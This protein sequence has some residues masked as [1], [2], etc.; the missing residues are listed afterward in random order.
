MF[1][2]LD[3]SCIFPSNAVLWKDQGPTKSRTADNCKPCCN[4]LQLAL[5]SPQALFFF[6][7]TMRSDP[8]GEKKPSIQDA[9]KECHYEPFLI[10]LQS[11]IIIL[12]RSSFYSHNIIHIVSYSGMS[13]SV[14]CK[15]A[16]S[17][18]GSQP[19]QFPDSP[20]PPGTVI[21]CGPSPARHLPRWY[22]NC[23]DRSVPAS[24]EPENCI[25]SVNLWTICWG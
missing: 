9:T 4:R 6:L 16:H 19:Q 25:Y 8:L 1:P 17:H 13:A 15:A 24:M 20:G 18:D 10:P 14:C 12:S 11:S 5:F 23:R 2:V 21:C 7:F 22:R 3:L